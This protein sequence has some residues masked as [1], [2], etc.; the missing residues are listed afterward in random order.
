MAP[1][2]AL[3]GWGWDPRQNSEILHTTKE[4]FEKLRVMPDILDC[5]FKFGIRHHTT[6]H[7][8]IQLK[9]RKN[10]DASA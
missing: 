3:I 6:L 5:R 10:T 9:N 7:D 8:M 1:D 2:V 4:E